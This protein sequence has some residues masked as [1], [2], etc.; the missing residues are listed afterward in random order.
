MKKIAYVYI[1]AAS[2][3][4]MS[5][6]DFLDTKNYTKKD[7]SNYP[8]TVTDAEQVLTGIYS[9]LNYSSAAPHT[10]YFYAAELASDDRFGGGGENDKLMQSLDLLMNNGKNMIEEFWKVRYGY[11]PSKHGHRNPG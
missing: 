11:F 10:S 6:E 8:E 2:L 5:C 7:T 4:L 3:L 1:V 9:N